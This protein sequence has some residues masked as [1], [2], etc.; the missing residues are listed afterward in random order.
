[1]GK[2][3]VEVR[4]IDAN[5]GNFIRWYLLNRLEKSN[6]KMISIGDDLTDEDMFQAF[7]KE[8]ITIKVGDP[9]TH[10]EYLIDS[11]KNILPF[12]Q[13]ILKHFT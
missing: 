5:K 8:A 4:C 1:M 2:K 6:A 9:P 7:T 3:I 13:I 11:Q 12:L 10:A